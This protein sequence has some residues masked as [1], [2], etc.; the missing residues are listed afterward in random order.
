MEA[1]FYGEVDKGL[2]AFSG[3]AWGSVN[4]NVLP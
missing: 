4:E 1:L 3:P 2:V